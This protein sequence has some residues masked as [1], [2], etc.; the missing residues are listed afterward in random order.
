MAL[1]KYSNKEDIMNRET[2]MKAAKWW[3]DYLRKPLVHHSNG[4]TDNANAMASLLADIQSVKSRPTDAAV[5]KFES[6]LAD[7]ILSDG[8]NHLYFGCDYHPDE[9]LMSAA[10]EAGINPM[11]FPWKVRMHI[12]DDVVTVS[13]GYGADYEEI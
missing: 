7:K 6:I 11:S 1:R 12:D 13:N 9:I 5:D 2:A 10:D 4:E 3:A 8:H